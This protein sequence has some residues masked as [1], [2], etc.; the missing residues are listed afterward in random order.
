MNRYF[1]SVGSNI[2]P[3]LNVI[4]ALRHLLDLSPQIHLSRI[5]ETE[6]SGG[7]VGT[8]FLNFTVCFDSSEDEWSL[9][10]K[11]N[12]IETKMGRDREDIDKKKKSRTIDLDILFGLSPEKNSVER[13]LIPQE[14]YLSY[15]LLELLYFLNI[16]TPVPLPTLPDGVELWID[17]IAIGKSPTTLYKPLDTHLIDVK[18]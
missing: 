18:E 3:Q 17:T 10:S 8:D 13:H 7:V 2:N 1:V 12:D 6:P 16:K 5:I 15:T 14:F 4:W 9:K 11:F